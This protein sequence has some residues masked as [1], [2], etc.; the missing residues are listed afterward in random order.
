[1]TWMVYCMFCCFFFLQAENGIRV[2]QESRG[3]GDV[4]KRQ[5]LVNDL[6][7]DKRGEGP[8]VSNVTWVMASD[9]VLNVPVAVVNG[10]LTVSI[11]GTIH[12]INT[13]TVV[14]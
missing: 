9:D 8:R 2:A 4:Y 1:M 11:R 5:A 13:Q 12:T 7:A 6:L 3:L 14:R 10:T